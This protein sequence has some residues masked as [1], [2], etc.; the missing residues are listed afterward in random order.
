MRLCL[1][2]NCPGFPYCFDRIFPKSKIN[3]ESAHQDNICLKCGCTSCPSKKGQR[4]TNCRQCREYYL[5]HLHCRCHS[6]FIMDSVPFHLPKFDSRVYALNDED[7][8]MFKRECEICHAKLYPYSKR[9]PCNFDKHYLSHEHF[10]DG[11]TASKVS[12]KNDASK[13]HFCYH[14]QRMKNLSFHLT[15]S[16]SAEVP[17]LAP[18]YRLG[19]KALLLPS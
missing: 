10:T 3:V 2:C 17:D 12:R 15:S 18:Y 13:I 11:D 8:D 4:W 1:S 6:W 16:G 7:D 19:G 9:E 14:C 5:S